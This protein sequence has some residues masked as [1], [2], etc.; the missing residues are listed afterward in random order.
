MSEKVIEY[1]V[2]SNHYSRTIK[3]E[4]LF[5][6]SKRRFI[7]PAFAKRSEGKLY[8][9]LLPGNYL[10]FE[11]YANTWK[12][13]AS[14]KIVMV[15]INA[16]GNIEYKDIFETETTY[17]DILNVMSDINAPYVL[18]EF[19]RMLPK[20]HSTAH[21]DINENYAVAETAQ[22]VIES[23]RKYFERKGVSQ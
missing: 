6:V 4:L 13:Y 9:R 8:Y 1:S 7:K 10:K 14:F 22:E 19:V 12:N 20:Y 5:S 23:I 18:A 21:V 2:E 11:L 17:D 3:H 16:N 15:H